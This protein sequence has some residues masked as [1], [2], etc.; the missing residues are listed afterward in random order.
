MHD[1]V[2][3]IQSNPRYSEA[4]TQTQD[5]Q[6]YFT[7]LQQAGY[8]TDPNYANKVLKVMNSE[9]FSDSITAV[10][11]SLGLVSARQVGE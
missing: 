5:A 6:Q 10:T 9:V 7:A 8:A 2:D 11:T 4:L 3:F 1:Y